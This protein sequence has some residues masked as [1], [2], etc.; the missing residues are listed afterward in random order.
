MYNAG[1]GRVHAGGTPKMTLDYVSR[2]IKR[3]RRID[4]FFLAEFVK[5]VIE[6]VEVP[7]EAEEEVEM[8]EEE[9]QGFSLSL[10]TPLGR[11]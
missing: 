11:L 7:E 2:I 4:D 6:I 1:M 8:E 3:H 9:V 10:L 5:P